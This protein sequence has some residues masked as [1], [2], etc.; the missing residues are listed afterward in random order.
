MTVDTRSYIIPTAILWESYNEHTEDKNFMANVVE[1]VLQDGFYKSMELKSIADK[2]ERKRI[3]AALSKSNIYT[4]VW[5]SKSLAT[6]NLD[7]NSLDENL[8][9]KTVDEVRKNIDLACE[10]GANAIALDG[11]NN[12]GIFKRSVAYEALIKSLSEVAD[13]AKKA[14]L[15]V[16]IES[17]DR[18]AHRKKLLS[19]VDDVHEVIELLRKDHKNVFISFDTAHVALNRENMISSFDT[20]SPFISQVH[21]S[22]A[23]LDIND[24]LYGDNHIAPGYPGFLTIK[25]AADLILHAKYDGFNKDTGLRVGVEF[26]QKND[27]PKVHRTYQMSADFLNQVILEVILTDMLKK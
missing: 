21:L 23:I 4:S 8:R 11:G 2:S 16:L 5:I 15:D 19:L 22:N 13:Y 6:Q 24:P 18:F 9:K 1:K 26:R 27:G 10:M 7:I 14:K 25:K 3:N 12:V 20:L 17:D